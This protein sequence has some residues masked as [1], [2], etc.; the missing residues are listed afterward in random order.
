MERKRPKVANT[1]L[2]LNN[3]VGKPTL[4]DLN[5]FYK[6]TIIKTVCNWQSNRQIDQWN[7]IESPEIDVHKYSHLIFDK[8]ARQYNGEKIIF[9]T[10]GAGTT[11]NTHSEK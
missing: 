9:P 5:T 2:K 1:I 8:G 4:P 3:K 11:G 6:A 10:N 7:N